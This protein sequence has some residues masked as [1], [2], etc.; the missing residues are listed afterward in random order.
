MSFYSS[1]RAESYDR[2]YSNKDLFSRIFSYLNPY[3]SKLIVIVF[4]LSMQGIFGALTPLLVSRVLDLIMAGQA[5]ESIYLW[6]VLGVIVLEFLNYI[7]YY[8]V[9]R[10]MARVIAD[11]TRDMSGA[12]FK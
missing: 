1:L 6:L 9:H 4:A 7:F 11:T 10:L 5:K 2:Q 3:R 8:I 12:A